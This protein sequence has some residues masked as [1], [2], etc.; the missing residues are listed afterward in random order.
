MHR[1][2]FAICVAAL[3]LATACSSG[4]DQAGSSLR[5][6]KIGFIFIGARDDLGYNQATWTGADAVARAFP[7]HPVLRQEN[8]PETTA[9]ERALESMIRD[10]AR[11]LFATSFGHLHYAYAVAKRHPEAIILHQGGVEPSP[12][13]DNFGT[14]WGTVYE[15]VYQAGIAAGSATTSNL[16][17]FVAAFP[18]P[19]TFANV[20]AFTL[21]ARSINPRARTQIVFTGAWCDPA[22]Q[23]VVAEQLLD[24]GADVLTQHQDCTRTILETADAAGALSVGYH[25]DGSEAAPRGWLVG[26]VWNW[27]PAFVDMVRTILNG[28]FRNSPYDGDF[29]G[30]Y[31]TMNNPFVLTEFGARVSPR[32]RAAIAAAQTRFASG[33]SPFTGPMK[34]RDGRTRIAAGQTLTVGQVDALDWLVPGVEGTV[35]S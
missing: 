25:E 15:P 16:L 33:G 29:R 6:A 11:I 7:N 3:L 35:P 20:N 17:G 9:A 27:K 26:S 2:L 14:Y 5:D 13:L 32:A 31:G 1:R 22:K 10:G 28:R 4:R 24:R 21:G 34:D 8:V 19:A 30:G 12:R 18:I 23:R